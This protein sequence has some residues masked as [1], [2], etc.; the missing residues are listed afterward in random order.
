MLFIGF[1]THMVKNHSEVLP[2]L[3]HFNYVPNEQNS[4]KWSVPA[5]CAVTGKGNKVEFHK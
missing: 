5:L 1:Y 4:C 3:R 2:S